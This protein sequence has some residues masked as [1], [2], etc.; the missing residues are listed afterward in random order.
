[1]RQRHLIYKIIDVVGFANKQVGA[2]PTPS[3][4]ILHKDEDGEVRKD[5][6]NY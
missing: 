3:I 5:I 4:H 6:W 1:M 2:E